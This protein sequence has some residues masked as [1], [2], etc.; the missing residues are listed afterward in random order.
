MYIVQVTRESICA[1]DSKLKRSMD[2]VAKTST[3]Y[4][5][6]LPDPSITPVT[7]ILR[8]ISEVIPLS[9]SIIHK[10]ESRSVADI[11]KQLLSYSYLLRIRV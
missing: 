8:C 1:I 4:E 11:G 9:K 3:I 2:I 10:L 6:G 7:T 5:K